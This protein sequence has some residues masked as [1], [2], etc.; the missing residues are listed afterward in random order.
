[1]DALPYRN[2]I[3][4]LY[5]TL[6]DIHT[7]ED[8]PEAWTALARF[9]G[10]YGAAYAPE[11]LHRAF[12]QRTEEQV[13][14]REGPRR[15]SHEAYPEIEIEE[16]FLALFRQKGVPADRTLAVHA[17]QFF[18]AMT[19][20]W[21]RLYDGVPALLRTLRQRGGRVYLLSNAQQIFTACE[22]KAL[23]LTPYFD[24]IYLSSACGCKK[25]DLRFFE[26]LLTEQHLAAD[27]SIMIGNDGLCDIAGAR[28]AGLATLYVRSDLSPREAPPPADFLLPAMD[29]P[30]MGR[31]LTGSGPQ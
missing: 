10:Y 5:G 24:A 4:D 1:M 9:Y 15:E 25:P 8:K 3:F 31:L 12:L 28:R 29:I 14:G 21:L 2:Y 18:R 7:A 27:Q 19:T 6:V 16:V 13:A 17:G 20:E 26:K 22:M 11:E 30:A 23:G